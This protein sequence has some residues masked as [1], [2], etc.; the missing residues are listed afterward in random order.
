MAVDSSQFGDAGRDAYWQ[1]TRAQLKSAQQRGDILSVA[2]L[3][4]ISCLLWQFPEPVEKSALWVAAFASIALA[5]VV[6]P[7]LF[8]ARRKRRISSGRGMNCRHCGY[9]PH[10]TEIS[11]IASTR[12]CSRCGNSLI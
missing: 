12:Q 11:E 9:V 7:Q 1:A 4:L 6:L 8:V 2:G 5:I 3:G 10:D